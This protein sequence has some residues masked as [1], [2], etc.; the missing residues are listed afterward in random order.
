MR[1]M[2]SGC[3]KRP[4]GVPAII[5]FSK[6][7]PTMPALCVPSVSTPPGAIA[8]TRIFRGPSSAAACYCIYRAL[9]P[10]IDRGRRLSRACNRAYV[11]DAAAIRPE[12]LASHGMSPT[13]PRSK[14]DTISREWVE[15]PKVI[16]L[17]SPGQNPAH[18]PTLL[19]EILR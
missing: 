16:S 3:P 18:D 7:L 2:S 5:V 12:V 17:S 10:G 9:G 13:T 14:V 6:S 8:L 11:D 15:T 19:Q 1:A 4:S